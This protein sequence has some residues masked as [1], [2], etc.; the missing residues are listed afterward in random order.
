MLIKPTATRAKLKRVL[1][2]CVQAA[3]VVNRELVLPY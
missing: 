3:L 1:A 2:K